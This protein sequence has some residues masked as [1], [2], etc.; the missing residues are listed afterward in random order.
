MIDFTVRGNPKAL[1]RHQTTAIYKKGPDGK[2]I[3]VMKNGRVI[4][5]Q[6]DPSAEDKKD[7]I[8]AVQNNAPETFLTGPLYLELHLFFQ[9]PKAHYRTGQHSGELKES[10]PTWH[11]NKFDLSNVQK[12]VE[13]SLN[14]IM[15]ADDAQI[16]VVFV[17]KKWANVY[18]FIRVKLMPVMEWIGETKDSGG[19]KE[20]NKQLAL[21]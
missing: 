4:T 9:R 2:P 3:P 21:L 10:A 12:F 17:Y 11:I 7:F 19:V 8:A 6:Y 16:S 20:H 15:Y 1:K 14:N 18:P 13:D 5:R